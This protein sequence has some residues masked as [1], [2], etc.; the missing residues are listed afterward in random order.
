VIL[1]LARQH[2]HACGIARRLGLRPE[3]WKFLRDLNSLYSEDLPVIIAS[4]DWR[5]RSDGNEILYAL[6]EMHA[7]VYTR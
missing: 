4:D 2:N 7:E 1:I 6:N 5:D 3:Q